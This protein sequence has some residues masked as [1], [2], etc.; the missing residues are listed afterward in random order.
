MTFDWSRWW[1]DNV[2]PIRRFRQLYV[3]AQMEELAGMNLNSVVLPDPPDNLVNEDNLNR[4]EEKL[5]RQQIRLI[6]KALKRDRIVLVYTNSDDLDR[7]RGG[8]TPTEQGR[9]QNGVSRAYRHGRIF[10]LVL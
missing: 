9:V 7:D 6:Q 2:H 3:A 4:W 8:L 10:C 5:C 1:D